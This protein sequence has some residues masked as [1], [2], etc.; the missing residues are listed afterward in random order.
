MD[1]YPGLPHY[2][3]IFPNLQSSEP[4]HANVAKGVKW[5]LTSPDEQVVDS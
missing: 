3:W 4:F 5:I 2:F 1:L